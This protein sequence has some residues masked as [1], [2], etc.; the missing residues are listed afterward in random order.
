MALSNVQWPNS[1]SFQEPCLNEWNELMNKIAE[2]HKNPTDDNKN[3]ARKAYYDYYDCINNSGFLGKT[4]NAPTMKLIGMG[5][6]ARK[7]RGTRRGHRGSRKTTRRHR[8]R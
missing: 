2:V 3:L 6:G 7:R 8:R 1:M 5:G 4:L